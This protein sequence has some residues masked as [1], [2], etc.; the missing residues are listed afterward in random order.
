MRLRFPK[1]TDLP[2]L[3][4][5][6]S[7]IRTHFKLLGCS[8]WRR[9]VVFDVGANDGASF[10]YWARLMPWA[11]F[12][13][14]EPTPSLVAQLRTSAAA[15]QNY[16]VISVAVGE[17]PGH[18]SF[19]IAGGNGGCSSLLE[20]EQGAEA[21][22]SIP[23]EVT[24]QRRITVDV[25]RLE[26]FVRERRITRIDFLHVDTQGTDLSVLRSLGS[27]LRR[28]QAGMIEAPRDDGMTLYRGQHTRKEALAFLERT[29]FHVWKADRENIY[30]RHL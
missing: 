26:D 7:Q 22:W 29:G 17:T 8:P 12:Y 21:T 13:A 27:E 16:E 3:W 18:A 11:Q 4:S 28:V 20:F 10:L 1:R 19:N 2:V 24:T 23:A 30:F 6:L 25:I 9:L 15:L 14:F 5:R